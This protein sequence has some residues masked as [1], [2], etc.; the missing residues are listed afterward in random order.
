MTSHAK[1]PRPLCLSRLSEKNVAP[2]T[3]RRDC[4]EGLQ[5]A[6]EQFEGTDNLSSLVV[7]QPDAVKDGL[8]VERS[9]DGGVGNF[10][11]TSRLSLRTLRTGRT[12]PDLPVR[13]R[14][15]C[16]IHRA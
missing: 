12:Y 13:D 9:G 7:E 6:K 3:G 8:P 15:H 2:A 11:V 16:E 14:S 1:E 10:A 4:P 5:I